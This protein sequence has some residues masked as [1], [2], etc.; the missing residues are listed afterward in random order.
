LVV[1]R[2]HVLVGKQRLVEVGKRVRHSL[3]ILVTTRLVYKTSLP[4]IRVLGPW[5]SYR[6]KS[7][8]VWRFCGISETENTRNVLSLCTAVGGAVIVR[9]THETYSLS[10]WAWG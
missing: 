1:L 7:V 8:A 6:L 10:H 2:K 9:L 4:E 3:S 5:L